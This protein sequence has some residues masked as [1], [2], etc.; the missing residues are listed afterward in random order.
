MTIKEV[1]QKYDI[2]ADTLRYYE[3][4]GV[5]PEVTRTAGGIRDY[6]EEDITWVE[7]ALCLRNAG[8]P[9]GVIAEYVRLYRMGDETFVQRRD[10][11]VAQREELQK[12]L[13]QMED[14][15]KRLDRK[16]ERC[17][18]AIESGKCGR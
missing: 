15:L 5:I 10:L 12:Q 2:T 1:C 11:L 18:Q 16:I 13:E 9:V 7:N 8:L 4:I 3:K 6:S 14:A 17:N